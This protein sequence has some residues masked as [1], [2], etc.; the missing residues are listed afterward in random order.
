MHITPKFGNARVEDYLNENLQKFSDLEGLESLITSVEIQQKY[1]EEQ[2]HDVQSKLSEAKL[3]TA[4][5]N[6][7][8]LKRV[9][10]FE[11]QHYR[12]QERLMAINSSKTP[13]VA[14]SRLKLPIEKLRRVELTYNYI[15]FLNNIESLKDDALEYLPSN[16]KLALDS[17]SKLLEISVSLQSFLDCSEEA[18]LYLNGHVQK[19]ANNLW[20]D[21]KKILCD[22]FE[23][24]LKKSNWPDLSCTFS[25]ECNEAFKKLLH[26]QSQETTKSTQSHILLPLKVIT[27]NILLEFQY[28][29]SGDKLTNQTNRLGDYFFEWFLSTVS[30]WEEFLLK[31]VAPIL[32]VHFKD[33]P[34]ATDPSFVDPIAAFINS[35][36][37]ILQEKVE[38]LAKQILTQP[39]LLSQFIIQLLDFDDSL[40]VR[41]KYGGSNH[42]TAKEGLTSHILEI[43]F[44][45]WYEVEKK[46][47][48]ERYQ[49]IVQAK[50]SGEID[51]DSSSIGKTKS[52]YG[53]SQVTDLIANIT[54]K[55][56][57]LQEFSHKIKFFIGIQAEILD[58]YLGRLN[59]A[60]EYYQTA[61]STVGR[62]IH[63][64]TK[65]ELDEIKGVKGLDK[66][67]RV[68]GSADYIVSALKEWI[69]DEFFL[70]IYDELQTRVASVDS[71]TRFASNIAASEV[72]KCMSKSVVSESDGSLFDTTIEAYERQRDKAESL[73][74]QAIKYDL[75]Q[76]FRPYLTK[77]QWT[78]VGEVPLLEPIS[79]LITPE[80]DLPLRILQT[81]VQFLYRALAMAPFR[82]IIRE[83]MKKLQ[84][85]LYFDLL[86]NQDFTLLGSVRFSQDITT[87]LSIVNSS[88][89]SKSQ[90]PFDMPLVREGAV[91]LTLPDSKEDIKNS[92]SNVSKAIFSSNQEA[93]QTLKN[94]GITHLSNSE[95]RTILD[96]R[97]SQSELELEKDIL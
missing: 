62:T 29:F 16:Y 30:K 87:I 32:A 79:T 85:L 84:D 40:R 53:S 96:R 65:E 77:S 94:L 19:T 10:E 88:L 22:E 74:T 13:E 23:K 50:N 18:T 80:L 28:H 48:L 51:Y 31:N 46:F 7:A 17:Y 63:G 33:S 56:K 5:R 8:M 9:D 54:M 41:F 35:L 3:A 47:A 95:A 55:Y 67:C 97:I 38:S 43:Y 76:L 70:V 52:S 42:H 93:T 66:L 60:L 12:V 14:L 61:N 26:F 71:T 2:L 11:K 75:P 1:L 69:H 68:F 6:S 36:F 27:K 39:Q 89:S 20:S 59:D 64:V 78:I 83:V 45:D 21:M 91:L 92:F 37:P 58:L 86:L 49:E 90:L 44:D 57:R 73:I 82:R 24:L 81:Y 72:I 34:L 4:D 15:Q 25:K